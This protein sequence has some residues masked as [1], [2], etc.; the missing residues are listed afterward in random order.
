MFWVCIWYDASGDNITHEALSV[1]CTRKRD[2]THSEVAIKQFSGASLWELMCSIW[3]QSHQNR[4]NFQ[5]RFILCI[6][7]CEFFF[8]L[9]WLCIYIVSKEFSVVLSVAC[10][11]IFNINHSNFYWPWMLL[12]IFILIPHTHAYFGANWKWY[13]LFEKYRKSPILGL[14]RSLT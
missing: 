11:L 10:H 5:I 9:I 7:F 2:E 4:T 3:V 1:K 13:D 12:R 6:V 14:S 8:S